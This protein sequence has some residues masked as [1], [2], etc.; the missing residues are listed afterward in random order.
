MLDRPGARAAQD[1]RPQAWYGELHVPH[2]VS[3]EA[4]P[5]EAD[6]LG[7]TGAGKTTTLKSIMGIIG[8]RTGWVRDQ[9]KELIGLTQRSHRAARH[10]VCPEE[11]GIFASL[12]VKENWLLPPKVLP[13]GLAV[14]P[15]SSCSLS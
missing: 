1:R 12:S 14:E 3:F 13:D 9:A 6:L 15:S 10:R 7:R 2:G 4:F 5:G 11:R 8:A